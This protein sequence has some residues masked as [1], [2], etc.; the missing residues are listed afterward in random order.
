MSATVHVQHLLA[1]PSIEDAL[2]K[3]DEWA[4]QGGYQIIDHRTYALDDAYDFAALQRIAAH[5][6]SI[7]AT[8]RLAS[9]VRWPGEVTHNY[10]VS[11]IARRVAP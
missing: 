6:S 4:A 7:S 5:E 10:R 8:P 3:V 11:V 2:A 1:A 9:D